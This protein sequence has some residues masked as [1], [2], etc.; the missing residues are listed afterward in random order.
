MNAQKF[1]QFSISWP[2]WAGLLAVVV[3]VPLALYFL[4]TPAPATQVTEPTFSREE[5]KQELEQEY[6]DKNLAQLKELLNEQLE[7]IEQLEDLASLRISAA[8]RDEGEVEHIPLFSP[9]SAAEIEKGLNALFES[10]KFSQSIIGNTSYV[11]ADDRSIY[12]GKDVPGYD[13]YEYQPV[14]LQVEQVN[15]KDGSLQ[16]LD[17]I[18]DSEPLRIDS[19]KR[20]VSVAMTASYSVPGNVK[21]LAFDDKDRSPRDGI[22]L[23]S[24]NGGEAAL[25]MP[26]GELDKVMYVQ[27]LDQQGLELRQDGNSSYTSD[28]YYLEKVKA[29]LLD[30]RQRLDSGEINDKAK[31]ITHYAQYVPSRVD[32]EKQHPRETIATFKFAGKPVSINVFLKPDSRTVVYRFTLTNSPDDYQN[33]MTVANDDHHDFYGI[34]DEQG[35]WVIKP[36]YQRLSS[37][38]DDY[39]YGVKDDEDSQLYYLDRLAKTLTVQPFYMMSPALLQDRFMVVHKDPDNNF[40][41]GLIDVRSHKLVLPVKYARIDVEGEFIW[42]SAEYSRDRVKGPLREVYEKNTMKL[43][44]SGEFD[45]IDM[46]GGNI[47]VNSIGRSPHELKSRQSTG[48]DGQGNYTYNNYDIYNSE[49]KRLN[50]ASYSE[51]HGEF[52]REGLLL[53][54]DI[55]GVKFYIDREAKMANLDISDYEEVEPFS[56]GLAAV[57]GH[58]GLFGYI[59]I[60]GNLVIPFMYKEAGYFTGGSAKVETEDSVMLISPNNQVIKTLDGWVNS[61][62]TLQDG[63]TARYGAVIQNGGDDDVYLTYNERGE[64][65]IGD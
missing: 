56:N 3:G 38:V 4:K 36:A 2:V 22:V 54:T 65:L 21:R 16:R 24:V 57:K 10:M 48:G 44:L 23:Q 35:Q 50:S 25:S 32:L 62:R 20:I 39:Y 64:L 43:I 46:E 18:K 9:P 15:F 49:G 53:V 34:I 19:N 37:A 63:D 1:K 27:A 55:K 31:L 7:S 52:S 14:V 42:T 6:A 59:D 45:D 40:I 13:V 61:S 51:V 5:I 41:K 30:T 17:K 8:D 60:K 11:Q 26:A 12:V 47:V 29:F 28:A 58:S 33:G